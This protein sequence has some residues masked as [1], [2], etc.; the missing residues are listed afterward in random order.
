MTLF[1]GR[2]DPATGRVIPWNPATGTWEEP[3]HER[4]DD[5]PADDPH[6]AEGQA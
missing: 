4:D 3:D 2:L 5:Q 1:G 6:E